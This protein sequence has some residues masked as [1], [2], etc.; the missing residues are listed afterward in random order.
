M[1]RV[2]ALLL[3]AA[4]AGGLQATQAG[5]APVGH[6]EHHVVAPEGVHWA[7]LGPSTSVAVLSGSPRDEGSPFVLR[8]KLAPGATVPPHWHP[9]DEHLTVVSGTL[10]MGM[11]ERLDRAAGTAMAAGAYALM[12]KAA[13]HYVWADGETVVQIHGVGPFT[14][15]FVDPRPK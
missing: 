4:T 5:Q 15:T 8:L 13:V 12:P 3:L 10:H 6:P 7:P 11:G 1:S 2:L 14:T 9:V